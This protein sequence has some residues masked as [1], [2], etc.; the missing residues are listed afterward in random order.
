MYNQNMLSLASQ[1]MQP[2]QT[3][4]REDY[5]KMRPQEFGDMGLRAVD[6]YRS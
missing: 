1:M 3:P 6:K 4:Y 2:A 5:V